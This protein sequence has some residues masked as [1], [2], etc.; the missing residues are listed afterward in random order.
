VLLA[1]IEQSTWA[2]VSKNLEQAGI[3]VVGRGSSPAEVARLTKMS[4]PELLVIDDCLYHLLHGTAPARRDAVLPAVLLRSGE[5]HP[6]ESTTSGV[7]PAMGVVGA[8]FSARNLLAAIEIAYA[9]SCEQQRLRDRV[10][11]LRLRLDARAPIDHAKKLL[12]KHNLMNEDEAY[13]WLR[14]SAMDQRIPMSSMALAV[15]AEFD[16]EA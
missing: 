10:A 8:P 1:V 16:R 7:I 3:N 9:R 2:L 5:D 4:S 6:I 11:K 15:V 13:R 12:M 14:R